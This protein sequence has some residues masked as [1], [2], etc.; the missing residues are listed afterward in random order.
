[1]GRTHQC[2]GNPA[3]FGDVSIAA[4]TAPGRGDASATVRAA[5]NAITALRLL[6]R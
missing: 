4:A 3:R 2:E 5:A 6:G 1:L